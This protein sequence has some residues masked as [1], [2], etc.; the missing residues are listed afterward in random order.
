MNPELELVA[1]G[2][3]PSMKWRRTIPHGKAIRLGRLPADGWAVSWDQRIS[4]EHADILLQDGVLTVRCLDAAKNP[5]HYRDQSSREVNVAP[6]E[7]FRIGLTRFQVVALSQNNYDT[8][9][10]VDE[11]LADLIRKSNDAPAASSNL[12]ARDVATGDG[13]DPYHR[14]LG[15]PPTHQPAHFYRLLGL[16][17]FESDEDVIHAAADRQM[18]HVR[19]YQTGKHGELSQVVLNEL[20]NARLSLLNAQKKTTYDKKLREYLAI[21]DIPDDVFVTETTRDPSQNLTGEACGGYLVIDQINSSEVGAIF[22]AKHPMTERVVALAVLFNEGPDAESRVERFHRKSR[23]MSH[24]S[25]KNIVAAH[26]VGKRDETLYLVMEFVDGQDLLETLKQRVTLPIAEVLQYAIQAAEG[27]G[28]AHASG[29]VHRNVKPSKLLIDR[30]G[31]VKVCGWGRSYFQDDPAPTNTKSQ[32]VIGSVDYMPPEQS[33]DSNQ[34]DHRADI[35]ALGCSVFTL[36]TRRLL[37]PGKTLRDCVTAHRKQPPP[38]IQQFRADAPAGLNMVLQKMLAKDP[39]E[40]FHSMAQAIAGM[41]AAEHSTAKRPTKK[42]AQRPAASPQ[43]ASPTE[44][45]A[46]ASRPDDTSAIN[47]ANFLGGLS[48]EDQQHWKRKRR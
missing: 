48:E 25:H 32:K 35:Y 28:H 19:A 29:I 20:T 38:P 33:F 2:P 44:K 13:F 26:E 8:S 40:R 4:R 17:T 5:A 39:N 21:T 41:Q 24:L 14:W 34:V 46:P 36:L 9:A 43:A 11:N 23:A 30:N 6:G 3:E 42:P 1:I 37:F 47:L 16:A 12:F 31:V 22:K 45:D 27:L 10:T 18:A 7:E 15:I